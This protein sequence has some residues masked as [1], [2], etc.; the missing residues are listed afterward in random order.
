MEKVHVLRNVT[1]YETYLGDKRLFGEVVED[2]RFEVGHIIQ[3]SGII[4][5]NLEKGIAKTET[6]SLYTFTNYMEVFEY[7]DFCEKNYS[8]ERYDF[9]KFA[10][11]NKE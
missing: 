10:I 4:E 11:R 1:A 6:G 2:D 3:T 7:L 9:I 8:K 5:L